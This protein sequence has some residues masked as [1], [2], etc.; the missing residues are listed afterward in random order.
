MQ[1]GDRARKKTLVD[2]GFRL[3]SAYDN[4]PLK[5]DEF[6][7]KVNQVL[8]VSATPGS[9]ERQISARVAEQIVRPTHL[10]DPAIEVRPTENQINDFIAEIEKRKAKNQ[11]VLGLTLTKRLAEALSDK[12]KEKKISAEY[13]HSEIRTLARPK[14]LADLRKGAYDAVIGINLLREGLDLPEVSLI[15]IF[16]AD[17][18]GFLRDETSLVQII[19]R[20]SRHPEGLSLIHI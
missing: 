7:K 13:L 3:P 14:I 9:Y 20:T 2:Y 10:L 4:R 11:R 6:L 17:K 18:E 1:I 12:L 15:A 16:D 5:F 19:G 8:F